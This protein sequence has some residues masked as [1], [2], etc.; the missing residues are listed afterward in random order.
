MELNFICP[1]CG[2]MLEYLDSSIAIEKIKDEIKKIE[3]VISNL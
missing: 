1:K 3:E 2:G